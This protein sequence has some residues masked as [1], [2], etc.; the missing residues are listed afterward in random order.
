[1]HFGFS[2]PPLTEPAGRGNLPIPTKHKGC[3]IGDYSSM[4]GYTLK[5]INTL[6]QE[7]FNS[8]INIPQ[9]QIPVSTFGAEGLYYIEIFDDNNTLLDTRKLILN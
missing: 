7:I 8:I 1:L 6:G 5:I 4:N 9:F 2:H 3:T